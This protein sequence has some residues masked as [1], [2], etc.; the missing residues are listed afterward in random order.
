[1]TFSL[2]LAFR[3]AWILHQ[4]FVGDPDVIVEGA[5]HIKLCRW[6]QPEPWKDCLLLLHGNLPA[7]G[8]LCAF[9]SL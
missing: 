8:V 5:G 1:M 6:R 9:L 7:L 2:L 3:F 4:I